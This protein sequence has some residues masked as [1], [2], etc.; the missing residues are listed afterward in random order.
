MDKI[1]LDIAVPVQDRAGRGLA[2]EFLPI[3]ASDKTFLQPAMAHAPLSELKIKIIGDHV[4]H[5][6][7]APCA[8]VHHTFIELVKPI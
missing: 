2:V 1:V 7:A 5:P 6:F 4:E 8:Y 3:L